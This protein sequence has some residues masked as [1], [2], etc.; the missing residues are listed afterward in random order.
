MSNAKITTLSPH[1][2]VPI[3]VK[4]YSTTRTAGVSQ[5]EYASLN[6]GTHVGDNIEHVLA[7]RALL[8]KELN[9][10]SEPIWLNQTHGNEVLDVQQADYAQPPTA[11]AA[12]TRQPNT[13][14]AVLTADCLPIILSNQQGSEIAV[15]H[16]GWRSLA[17]GIIERVVA[18]MHSDASS[19]AAWAG[20][21]IGAEAF[22]IDS[23]V[24]QQLAGPQ[25][26]YCASATKFT[27]DLTL[28]AQARLSELGVQH[29]YCAQQCTYQQPERFF[30]HR[31][32]QH[33]NEQSLTNSQCGRMGTFIWFET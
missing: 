26:A 33:R 27:A 9:M 21:C 32:S 4:A 16:A 15:I 10:P 12:I 17:S 30:S 5:G 19:L 11:D 3:Q 13:V 29:Y 25:Q 24:R 2:Q 22:V 1:W 20:P 23:S 28:L 31:R 6:L 14:L 8:I 18:K 7:N